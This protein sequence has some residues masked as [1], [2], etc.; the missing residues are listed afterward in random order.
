MQI[1]SVQPHVKPLK[2]RSL[3]FGEKTGLEG[4]TF[5][6]YIQRLNGQM[7]QVTTSLSHNTKRAHRVAQT[8]FFSNTDGGKA[9]GDAALAHHRDLVELHKSVGRVVTMVK[10]RDQRSASSL[11]TFLVDFHQKLGEMTDRLGNTYQNA[12]RAGDHAAFFP[13]AASGLAL[14]DPFTQHI[15]AMGALFQT[16]HKASELAK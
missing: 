2:P 16:F 13:A 11:Q 9:L 3:R 14:A 4:E 5:R 15:E 7:D 8:S 12:V 6:D 1:S 10:A